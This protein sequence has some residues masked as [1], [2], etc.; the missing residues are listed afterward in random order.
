M[1]ELE[2]LQADLKEIKEETTDPREM[3]QRMRRREEARGQTTPVGLCQAP[4]GVVV[5]AELG[6]SS[7]GTPVS[8][9]VFPLGQSE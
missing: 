3:V 1:G 9:E 6:G 8:T 5:T 2:Q 7:T 4:G